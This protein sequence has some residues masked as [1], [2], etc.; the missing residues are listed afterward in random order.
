MTT[1][2]T[3]D[4]DDELNSMFTPLGLDFVTP[5]SVPRTAAF[6]VTPAPPIR[7]GCLCRERLRSVFMTM[8]K[9]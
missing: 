4:H 3:Q 2:E 6:F 1:N 9:A 8:A 5:A 7:T